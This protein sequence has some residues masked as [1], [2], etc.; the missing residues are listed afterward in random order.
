MA[1][2]DRALSGCAAAAVGGAVEKG[3]IRRLA[4]AIGEHKPVYRDEDHLSAFGATT[5]LADVLAE[6]IWGVA[7]P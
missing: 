2:I 6:R 1:E 4:E 7:A 3:A 5:L